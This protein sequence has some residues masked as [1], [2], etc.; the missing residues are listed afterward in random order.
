[1]VKYKGDRVYR[2][3]QGVEVDLFNDE[4]DHLSH[5]T[6]DS[7]VMHEASYDVEAHGNVVVVSDSGVV[8]LTQRLFYTKENDKVYSDA[9]VTIVR[10]PGDTLYGKGFESDKNLRNYTFYEPRGVT[11]RKIDLDLER[12]VRP[13]RVRA[14]SAVGQSRPPSGGAPE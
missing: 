10:G 11:E 7:G 1:M 6:A 9:P 2:F 8:L 5:V 13:R 12:H 14:D 4:G 3:D